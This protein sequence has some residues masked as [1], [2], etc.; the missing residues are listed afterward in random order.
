MN[1]SVRTIITLIYR[2]NADLFD[3]ET[4][5]DYDED[6][7]EETSSNLKRIIMII[8]ITCVFAAA[9][10]ALILVLVLKAGTT[11]IDGI[12]RG[13]NGYTIVSNDDFQWKYEAIL[14]KTESVEIP[15]DIDDD[16][17]PEYKDLKLK[18]SM[19]NSQTY[20][21]KINP[22][23][24]NTSK[25]DEFSIDHNNCTLT[26]KTMDESNVWEVPDSI[27]GN[28]QDDYS[29]RLQLGGFET[30]DKQGSVKTSTF[31][32]FDR[33]LVMSKYYI[34][35]GFLVDSNKI[36]GF[37]ERTREFELTEGEYT[38]WADGRDTRYDSGKKGGNSYGDH[39][40]VLMRLNNGKFAGIFFKNSNAK[41]LEYTQYTKKRSVLNFKAIGGILDFFMFSGETADEVLMQ[42][43]QVIG[44]PYF[45]PFW[46]LGYHQ[47]SWRYNKTKDLDEVISGY[48]D[49]QIPLESIWLD[50]EYMD[51]Y[52]NFIVNKTRFENLRFTANSLHKK[53]QKL[54][55]IVDAGLSAA[56]DYQ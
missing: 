23:F 3:D 21:M 28:V 35:L 43:H 26:S 56:D 12:P 34:E 50:I 29:T 2:I 38:S 8:L 47:S 33:N 44:T 15:I 13:Y 20:R 7:E 55:T 1:N 36:F 31:S 40:F 30:K 4:S 11:E 52:R 41:V 16:T 51:R 32:T 39:P 54:I 53:N 18:V 42:Y 46:A 17:N 6:E 37:G 22:I 5:Q 25:C 27:L 14:Q 9:I 49:H 24:L 10:I 48:S 19:M 45:P